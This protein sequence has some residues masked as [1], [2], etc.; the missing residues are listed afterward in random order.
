MNYKFH[1]IL[2]LILFCCWYIG[3]SEN[4]PKAESFI[5]VKI[6]PLSVYDEAS[7]ETLFWEKQKFLFPQ[8]EIPNPLPKGVPNDDSLLVV[9]IEK[10]GKIKLNKQ[11]TADLSNIEL[12]QTTLEKI[13]REREKNNVFEP[14]SEKIVKITAVRANRYLK[15]GDVIKVIAAIKTTGADPIILQIDNPPE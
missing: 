3:C 14:N 6:M 8:I 11:I 15:Y 2:I 1:R 12:L 10:D 13:F 5:I 9:S 4:Q 7:D